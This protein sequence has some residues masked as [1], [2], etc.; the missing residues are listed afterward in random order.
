MDRYGSSASDSAKFAV[1]RT[2]TPVRM[3]I[4]APKRALEKVLERCVSL[5]MSSATCAT[6]AGDALE[7]RSAAATTRFLGSRDREFLRR[8]V[9]TLRAEARARLLD[10]CAAACKAKRVRGGATLG[11]IEW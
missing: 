9:M 8:V 7:P 2:H 1:T 4:R 10:L 11:S 6:R 5:G 3:L